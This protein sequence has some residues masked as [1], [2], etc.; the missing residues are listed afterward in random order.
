[1]QFNSGKEM[2]DYLTDY[3]DLYSKDKE[4]YV[5][6]YDGYGGI[7]Y[8]YIDNEEMNEL[9]AKAKEI[10]DYVS[11]FLGPGGRIVDDASNPDFGNTDYNNLDWCNDNY[12]G[13]WD[14]MPFIK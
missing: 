6:N 2:L 4:I 8:Y 14:E 10:D 5:F 1:M 11:A 9:R 13:E 12:T 3:G 7:V